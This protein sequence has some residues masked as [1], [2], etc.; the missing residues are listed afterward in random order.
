MADLSWVTQVL[1]DLIRLGREG[2]VMEVRLRKENPQSPVIATVFDRFSSQEF[3]RFRGRLD[4][5]KFRGRVEYHFSDNAGPQRVV[6]V[7]GLTGEEYRVMGG[8][9]PAVPSA[10]VSVSQGNG[11]ALRVG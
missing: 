10:G 4:L 1:Q 11:H 9:R 3:D 5:N 8:Y 2:L 6:L 7:S